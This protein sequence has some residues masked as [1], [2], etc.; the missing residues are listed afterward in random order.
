[1]NQAGRSRQ[2][3]ACVLRS[4]Q[5]AAVVE[6]RLGRPA[7]RLVHTLQSIK[8]GCLDGPVKVGS[9]G[10]QGVRWEGGL[11]GAPAGRLRPQA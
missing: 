5:Q 10:W 11:Q 9:V 4:P 7:L 2:A 8:L 3:V 6:P 1:M